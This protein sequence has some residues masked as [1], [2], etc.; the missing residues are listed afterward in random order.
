MRSTFGG[1]LLRLLLAFSLAPTL[2]MALLG[3]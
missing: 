3:L 2:L 1:K